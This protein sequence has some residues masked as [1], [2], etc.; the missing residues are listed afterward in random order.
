MKDVNLRDRVGQ[1][2]Q[3][4][5]TA[6]LINA[7]VFDHDPSELLENISDGRHSSYEAHYGS[8]RRK[9]C[10]TRLL[11]DGRGSLRSNVLH[12][13]IVIT[14]AVAGTETRHEAK[15]LNSLLLQPS[16]NLPPTPAFTHFSS[17]SS[18][19]PQTSIMFSTRSWHIALLFMPRL[20]FSQ[21]TLQKDYFQTNFFDNFDFF[22][23]AD[24]T[25]GFVQY[26]G[27]DD[28]LISSTSTNAV[29][30]VS[31]E[32]STPNGRPSIRIT[33]QEAYKT[34]LIILD[35]SHMPGGICGTWCV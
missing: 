4:R 27:Q 5:I 10:R 3:Q 18:H 31:T 21:Y 8:K 25:N 14:S 32:Q 22:D 28:S 19:V 6:S 16:F 7:T 2:N 17:L 15:Y 1:W 33:S 34:G 11:I 20:I 26:T 24:P 13:Q 23:G 9:I 29:M 35:L 12:G 30:R